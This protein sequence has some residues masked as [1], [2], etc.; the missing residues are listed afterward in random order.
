MKN[1]GYFRKAAIGFFIVLVVLNP[2]TYRVNVQD[3]VVG[4][5]R[6]TANRAHVFIAADQYQFGELAKTLN[7]CNLFFAAGAGQISP[8]AANGG[9]RKH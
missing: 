6:L 3:Q 5:M 7:T 9:I 1:Q 8:S 4:T 2:A